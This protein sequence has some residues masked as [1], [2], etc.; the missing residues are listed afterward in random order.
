MTLDQ[1]HDLKNWHLRH[2][3]DRPLEG[4]AWNM[5]LTLWL[6]GWVGTPA[7][8]LIGTPLLAIVGPVLLLLPG[9]YVALRHRLHRTG[10]LRCDW[11]G[12]LGR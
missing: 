3:Q 2:A 11:L 10:H 12:A 6:V 8:W 4:H 5:V 9:A 7:A 1:F